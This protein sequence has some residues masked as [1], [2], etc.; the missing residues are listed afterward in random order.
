MTAGVTVGVPHMQS[1]F[2]E[3]KL[4]EDIRSFEQDIARLENNPDKKIKVVV[5][6]PPK[7]PNAWYER[8]IPFFG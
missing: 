3:S 8:G 2:Q 5:S 7:A 4:K 1:C 6:R